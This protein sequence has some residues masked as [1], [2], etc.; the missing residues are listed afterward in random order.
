MI[1]WWA[2]LFVSIASA[3]AGALAMAFVA[4]CDDRRPR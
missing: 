2:C 1:P 3:G 4:A